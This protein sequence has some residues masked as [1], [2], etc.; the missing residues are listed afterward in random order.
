[1]ADARIRI[2]GLEALSPTGALATILGGQTYPNT[3]KAIESSLKRVRN[4]AIERAAQL[5]KNPSGAWANGIRVVQTSQLEGA[6]ISTAP[7][8]DIVENGHD[9]IEMKKILQTSNKVRRAMMQKVKGKMVG[10]W[11]FLYIPFRHKYE[12]VP[13]NI[14]QLLEDEGRSYVIETYQEPSVQTGR[15]GEPVTRFRYRWGGRYVDQGDPR[16]RMSGMVKM[17]R[18]KH[19]AYTTF[20]TM[21]E[22]PK[23]KAKWVIQA[24]DGYHIFEEAN[25]FVETSDIQ[26]RIRKGLIAD[27]R[28]AVPGGR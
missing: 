10:G 5:M 15:E 7:H 13:E 26:E 1:M 20:R 6:V 22:N 12:D 16:S 2:T 27:I 21:T 19:G 9:E 14:R 23:A 3:S 25:Q 28:G 17:G 4:F 11:R 18:R 24:R 8:H